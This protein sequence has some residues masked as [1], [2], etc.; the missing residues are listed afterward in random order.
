M[1]ILVYIESRGGKLRAAGLEA[2][3]GA[4]KLADLTGGKLN[5][6]L[7]GTSLDAMAGE[8]EGYGVDRLLLAEHPDLENY[9]PEGHREALLAAVQE[10]GAK[11]VVMSASALG[12]DL[13]PTVAARLDAAFLPDCISVEYV[14]GRLTVTRPVYAGRCIMTLAATAWPA[15]VT[16]RPKAFLAAPREVAAMERLPL[17]VSLDG[18]IRARMLEFLTEAGE[19]LDVT[20]ADTV[21]SG[22]RGMKGAE[23]FQLIE[24]LAETLGGAVGAS[25]AVVDAEWR[26]HSEQVG[27]TGK[28]VSPTLYIAC[29]ISGAIQ[30]LAGMRSSK[31]I[32][33]VNKD[34][35]APIFKTA[36]YGIVGDAME[37][38]PALT[39]A[40]KELN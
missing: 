14:E 3:S 13:G 9:S 16:L 18:K 27:Q 29:G 15:V 22:G 21:V 25:R 38:L 6:L 34:P 2:V 10:S 31:V 12:R 33:A 28:L 26:P 1:D 11:L 4:R 20:E 5:A 40:L 7:I 23:N 30:H 17:S 19:K 36:D 8:V 24:E 37:V 35:E 32:V 39:K